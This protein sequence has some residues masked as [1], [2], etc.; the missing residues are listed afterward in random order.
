MGGPGYLHPSTIPRDQFGT[1]QL[2]APQG[3]GY[4]E[5]RFTANSQAE[6][7][8]DQSGAYKDPYNFSNQRR[9]M[10]ER[11]MLLKQ[12]YLENDPLVFQ[13]DQAIKQLKS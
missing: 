9:L 7:P 12:G 10:N 4:N 1:A 2:S 11:A 13:I 5:P 6:R 8:T 3:G